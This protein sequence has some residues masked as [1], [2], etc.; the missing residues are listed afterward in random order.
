MIGAGPIGL[1]VMQFV[2]AA[3]CRLIVLDVSDTRLAF[4][5]DQLKVQDTIN[6]NGADPA[7]SLAQLTAGDATVVIDATGNP[8]S[9]MGALKFLAHGGR[10]VYVGLFPGDFALNIPSFTSETTL[11]GTQSLPEDF[12]HIIKLIEQGII[13]TRPWITHRAPMAEA[14]GEFPRWILPETGVLKAIIE[15]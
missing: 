2:L 1:S 15:F 14:A 12:T 9:M 6:P 8:Q 10:L 13:D 7:T 3:K 5:R 11:M 4:C